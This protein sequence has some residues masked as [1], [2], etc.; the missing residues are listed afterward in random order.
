MEKQDFIDSLT[1][2]IP[3]ESIDYIVNYLCK[4]QNIIL[5]IKPERKYAVGTYHY[6]LEKNEHI[7]S[8]NQNLNSYSFLFTLVHEIAHM[9]TRI[10]YKNKKIKPHGKE[11]QTIFRNL[12]TEVQ[13]F[14]PT[15]IQNAIQN[16]QKDMRAATC[17][18]DTLYKL[19]KK[20]DEKPCLF[21]DD[22]P[23]N[24]YFVIENDSRVFQKKSVLR[25]NY[26]CID[27][28]TKKE[29]RVSGLL[30]VMLVD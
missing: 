3:S 20:Y 18:D 12:L 6:D 10:S 28:K 8:M 1:Q 30:E 17:R 19:L 11:W 4:W 2:Y 21:L 22:I 27:I 13:I 15:D 23:I 26:K 7:I 24:A 25:K 16:Y 5:K 9:E 29:Y 14:F